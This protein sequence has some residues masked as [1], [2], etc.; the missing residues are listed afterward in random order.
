M[1]VVSKLHSRFRMPV[2]RFNECCQIEQFVHMFRLKV[3]WLD[4]QQENKFNLLDG[5]PV[6]NQKQIVYMIFEGLYICSTN[7]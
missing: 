7:E 5:G 3:S 6:L 4:V 2:L 1:V